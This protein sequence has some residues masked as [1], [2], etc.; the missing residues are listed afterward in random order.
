MKHLLLTLAILTSGCAWFSRANHA[1]D[2]ASI[3]SCISGEAAAG[4]SPGEIAL[5]CGLENADEVIDLITKSQGVSSAAPKMG[6]AAPK[7]SK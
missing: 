7:A 6:P 3:L 4:K 1:K 2:L 5:T